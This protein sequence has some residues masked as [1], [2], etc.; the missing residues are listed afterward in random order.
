MDPYG[1]PPH[2][3]SSSS[4]SGSSQHPSPSQHPLQPWQHYPLQQDAGQPYAS[5]SRYP[6]QPQA[7]PYYRVP[8]QDQPPPLPSQA[9]VNQSHAAYAPILPRPAQADGVEREHEEDDY[10]EGEDR[11][12]DGKRKA[13]EEP[14]KLSNARMPKK[15]KPREAAPEGTVVT[16]KSCARCRARKVRC[17][18]VFPRCDHC[19]QRNEQCD[20]VDWKPKPK[21]KPTDPARVAQL[22][23]RL[24]ELEEQLAKNGKGVG[25]AEDV[26]QQDGA[27]E[28]EAEAPAF[29]GSAAALDLP[30]DIS[31]FTALSALSTVASA[32]ASDLPSQTPAG[33]PLVPLSSARQRGNDPNSPD[34][35][36]LVSSIGASSIDWRLATP[37]MISSLSRHLTEAFAE[38]CCILLP[39]YDFF[40]GKMGDYLRGEEAGLTPAQRV[41]LTTFCAVGARTS[42]HSALI[43]VSLRPSDAVDHPNA[44]LLSAG[45]RRQNACATLLSR[46]HLTNHEAGTMEEPS[47]ENL[48]ALLSLLQLCTFAELVPS[49]SRPLL[50]SAVSHFKELQD[51]AETEEERA[52][53]RKTFGLAI[54]TA[55][56]TI[57]AYARR[58]ALI[59]DEDLRTF[60]CHADTKIIVPRLPADALLPIVEKLVK[61]VPSRDVALK[62]AKHLLQCWTCACQRAFVQL[63]APPVRPA[64][65]LAVALQKLWMAID[66]T[67]AAASFLLSIAPPETE[68]H[69]CTHSHRH[70]SGIADP[71]HHTVHETDFGAQFARLDRDLLDLINMVHVLIRG[72]KALGLPSDLAA[73]SLSRVRRGLRRRAS[74]FKA[75]VAGVDVHMTFHELF[76]LEHLHNWTELALQRIGDPGG[77]LNE[78][79]EVSEEELSWFIE[80]LQHCAFYHP[81]AEKRLIELAPRFGDLEGRLDLSPRIAQTSLPPPPPATHE[82]AWS[83]GLVL[84]TERFL[85]DSSP[86]FP[87]LLSGAGDGNASPVNFDPISPLQFGDTGLESLGALP[88]FE[89]LGGAFDWA[90]ATPQTGS[91][92]GRSG[93][94]ASGALAGGQGGQGEEA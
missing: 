69:V 78:D 42:P 28:A 56:C 19:I 10:G 63:A 31:T 38:S 22:E 34:S 15:P 11:E 26:R 46:A 33:P 6:R 7:Q 25:Q 68:E 18:R 30:V 71:F 65:E 83:V 84:G 47:A 17:N 80:G 59:T 72:L 75:Y 50:R 52:W 91:A 37:Q 2:P 16:D 90:T 86:N 57:S 43:G 44:P 40:R 29:L 35:A 77:P 12:R 23:K 39:T 66:S 88:S 4:S 92:Q 89:E 70:G 55:D 1:W 51:T 27:A 81:K 87:S 94:A 21:V 64:E 13:S 58:K 5:T 73:A 85:A 93:A 41:A 61:G 53:L 60:F 14:V 8:G 24:A 20:L 48:A 54:Y 32:S 36:A 3:P 45:T 9:T 79:E 76:Q 74:Y 67:R 49:K 62:S 82:Q